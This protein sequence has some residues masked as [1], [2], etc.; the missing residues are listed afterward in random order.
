MIVVKPAKCH[1]QFNIRIR[2]RRAAQSAFTGQTVYVASGDGALLDVAPFFLRWQVR[3][4][5]AESGA[6][7]LKVFWDFVNWKPDLTLGIGVT[8]ASWM[9]KNCKGHMLT[10][11]GKPR[12]LHDVLVLTDEPTSDVQGSASDAWALVSRHNVPCIT[13]LFMIVS[14]VEEAYARFCF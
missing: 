8:I 2:L 1:H 11:I 13:S 10:Y 12:P 7:Y 6:N 14:A 5:F 3:A 9:T 4:L